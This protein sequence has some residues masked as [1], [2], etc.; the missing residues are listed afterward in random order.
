MTSGHASLFTIGGFGAGLLYKELGFAMPLALAAAPL[1]A[2][3]AAV[4]IGFFCVRLSHAYFIMLSL[5]F[6]QLV[7]TVIWKW[8]SLTGGDDGLTGILPPAT[9]AEPWVY[10]YFVLAVVLAC[11]AA[12]YRIG[13]SP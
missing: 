1:L 4:V 12:L 11:T 5:A 9:M 6:G 10:Y 2:A 13:Q 3:A 8:R 7:F